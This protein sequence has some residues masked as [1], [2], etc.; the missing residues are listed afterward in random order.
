MKTAWFQ[1]QATATRPGALQRVQKLMQHPAYD[2]S[3]PNKVR[4]LVAAFCGANPVNFHRG[5]GSGYRFLVEQVGQIDRYN[6]QL[7]SRL[8]VPL[9]RWKKYPPANA[10]AMRGALEALSKG[11][12]LSRD[13][14]EIVSKSL[15]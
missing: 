9:T 12:D 5:D 4:S 8:L 11:Q 3:N 15:A 1:I 10:A 7:A 14:Y 6:P 2:A 13:V